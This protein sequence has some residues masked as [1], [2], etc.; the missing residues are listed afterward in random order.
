MNKA[1]AE[2]ISMV[3]RKEFFVPDMKGFQPGA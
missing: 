2:R 3:D 1:I